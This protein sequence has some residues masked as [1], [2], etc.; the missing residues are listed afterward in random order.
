MCW[1]GTHVPAASICSIKTYPA[2]SP[3][4]RLNLL[5]P[6][7]SEGN[8]AHIWIARRER[9]LGGGDEE[10]IDGKR[11]LATNTVRAYHHKRK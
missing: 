5:F 11:L 7:D 2:N 6:I 3:N 9:Y 4:S 1:A 10:L 8:V